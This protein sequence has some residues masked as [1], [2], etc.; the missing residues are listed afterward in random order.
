MGAIIKKYPVSGN[1]NR[2]E[3]ASR[4]LNPAIAPASKNHF[5]TK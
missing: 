1:R 5:F 2:V 3:I 4:L